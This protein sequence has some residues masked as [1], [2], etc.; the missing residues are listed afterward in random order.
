MNRS[1]LFILA[2]LSSSLTAFACGYYPYGEDVRMCF[3]R[4]SYYNYYWYS[5]FYYT[6]EYFDETELKNAVHDAP[7]DLFWYSYCKGKVPMPSIKEAVYTL[8]GNSFR[9]GSENAMA[10]YLYGVND[11]DAVYYLDFAKD[12]EPVNGWYNDPWERNEDNLEKQRNRLIAKAIGYSKNAKND[13][14]RKR[15]AFLAMR[16]AFYNQKFDTINSL[17]KS[18][19]EGENKKDIVYYWALYFNMFRLKEPAEQSYYAAQVFASAP[20]KRF[21]TYAMFDE[22]MPLARIL[23]YAKTDTERANVYILAAVRKHDKALG[24]ME[25]AYQLDPSNEGIG[26]LMLREINKLEDWIYTPYY[27]LFTPSVEDSYDSETEKVILERVEEDRQY[28]LKVLAFA[29]AVQVRKIPSGSDAA[30]WIQVQAQLELLTK[31]YGKCLS[32]ISRIRK[33]VDHGTE[34]YKQIER[35]YALALTANQEYGKAIIPDAVKP[36]LLDNKKD[37]KFIFAV[38]RELEYK[39]NTT[40]AVLLYANLF[41]GYSDDTRKWSS[42]YWKDGKGISGYE[43]YYT[44]W[45]GYLNFNYSPEQIQLVINDIKS[46]KA[47]DPFSKWKY[48][49]ITGKI[50]VLYDLL[51]T[52]YMR[53]NKLQAACDA[54]SK[55]GDKHWE[56]NYGFWERTAYFES[57]NQFDQNPFYT[58]KHTPEFIPAQDAIKINKYTVVKQ[59]MHYLKRVENVNEKDRDYYYFLVANCYFN[60]TDYGNSWMMRRFYQS[61]EDPTGEVEDNDEYY[62]CILAKKYYNLAYTYSKTP[63]FKALC[64]RMTGY[65]ESGA[66]GSYW[67]E[68]R[69]SKI[70]YPAYVKL[71]RDYPEYS[72]ELSN[73][74]A[75]SDY[76]KARR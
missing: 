65:C 56:T 12:C 36:V 70:D 15:Y 60:M 13:E 69:T 29:E 27:T 47:A 76:F 1:I 74:T 4:P 66:D 39:G 58:I 28:A 54:F 59:L 26:F 18:I 3:F 20:D 17:F 44:D 24:Y 2:L 55:A 49:W 53:Q 40:D 52:K 64:L 9:P 45:F 37:Q 31:Q 33:R 6:S 46:N 75:F 16:M 48:D 22:K 63:K 10:K 8:S 42:V 68:E 19:F 62:E 21:A 25:Q 51:G 43:D 73:C 57:G 23:K 67:D 41:D 34:P 72:K 38:A 14:F 50:T 7:N 32:T 71:K 5:N 30:Y 61:S 11:L 35:L